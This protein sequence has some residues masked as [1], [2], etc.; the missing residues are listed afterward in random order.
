MTTTTEDST[1]AVAAPRVHWWLLALG[2]VP[3]VGTALLTARIIWEQTVW[4]WERGM[5]AITS[6]M[7]YELRN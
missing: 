3:F 4:T 6:P 5:A 1:N 7:P 2:V